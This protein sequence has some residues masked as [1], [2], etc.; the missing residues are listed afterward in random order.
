MLLLIVCNV[1]NKY[2]IIFE[3]QS[4]RERERNY[5]ISNDNISKLN[6]SFSPLYF[7]SL[8]CSLTISSRSF[9]KCQTIFVGWR[10][11]GQLDVSFLVIS[12]KQSESLDARKFRFKRCCRRDQ[13]VSKKIVA[14][15]WYFKRLANDFYFYFFWIEFALL[16]LKFLKDPFFFFFQ[17]IIDDL[18]I[19]WN[20]YILR[21]ALKK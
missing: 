17:V 3:N 21:L 7:A 5:F 16:F 19:L 4:E 13:K 12:T 1:W 6:L 18:N 9:V 8:C 15:R 10:A 11:I 2:Q 20:I 14:N